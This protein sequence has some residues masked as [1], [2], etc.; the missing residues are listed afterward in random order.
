M[1]CLLLSHSTLKSMEK[2]LPY[3][4]VTSAQAES[5]CTAVPHKVQ[6]EAF[7]TVCAAE[8]TGNVM[9]DN[10]KSVLVPSCVPL[11]IK[12]ECASCH[13]GMEQVL[14]SE[15]YNEIGSANEQVSYWLHM[16]CA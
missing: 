5:T 13:D 7:L 10:Q 9:T 12:P 14:T 2:S 15:H 16:Q 8:G 3:K 6:D 1:I 11:Q 4:D